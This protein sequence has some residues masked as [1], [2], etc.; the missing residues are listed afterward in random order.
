[1]L[2]S[3]A[4]KYKKRRIV[5]KNA[6]GSKGPK[7]VAYNQNNSVSDLLDDSIKNFHLFV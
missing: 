3:T 6:D 7:F 4:V 2:K 5:K 1:M